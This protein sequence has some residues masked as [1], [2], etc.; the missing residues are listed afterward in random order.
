[1]TDDMETNTD[2]SEQYTSTK[3]AEVSL[4]CFI[5]V[6]QVEVYCIR[7]VTQSHEHYLMSYFSEILMQALLLYTFQ[8]NFICVIQ[9]WE[10]G[11]TEGLLKSKLQAPIHSL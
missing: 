8:Y 9:V 10:C 7:L 1:M 3:T 6:T 4:L 11:K 2:I 5:T